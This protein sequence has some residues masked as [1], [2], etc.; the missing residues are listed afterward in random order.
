MNSSPTT[1]CNA[2]NRVLPWSATAWADRAS[3]CAAYAQAHDHCEAAS[4]AT[5]CRWLAEAVAALD[6]GKLRAVP[7]W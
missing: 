2:V 3:A 5:T 7:A 4:L 1:N 6:A